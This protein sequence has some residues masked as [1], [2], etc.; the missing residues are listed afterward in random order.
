M[1]ACAPLGAMARLGASYEGGEA[2]G[3][4][5]DV[6]IIKRKGEENKLMSWDFALPSLYTTT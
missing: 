4:F 3:A 6:D 5:L 2:E 1:A